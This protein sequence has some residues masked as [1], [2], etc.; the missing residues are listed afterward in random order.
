MP[1]GFVKIYSRRRA[2]VANYNLTDVIGIVKYNP[3]PTA[4]RPLEGT[5]FNFVF[6]ILIFT[7]ESTANRKDIAYLCRLKQKEQ[8]CIRTLHFAQSSF[9]AVYLQTA[10]YNSEKVIPTHERQSLTVYSLQIQLIVCLT[11]T[12]VRLAVYVQFQRADIMYRRSRKAFPSF[13]VI[14]KSAFF[15]NEIHLQL[16]V[17]ESTI[18]N[19]F[20]ANGRR[21]AAKRDIEIAGLFKFVLRKLFAVK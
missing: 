8:T 5:F 11:C 12:T 20:V 3:R 7:V 6:D 13:A 2:T 19:D 4:T 15:K 18:Q 16:L 17:A 9:F 21:F 1:R 14:A 10:F